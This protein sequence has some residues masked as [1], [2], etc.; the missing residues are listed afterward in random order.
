MAMTAILLT[1]AGLIVAV[2]AALI[3]VTW[4]A[5]QEVRG[6]RDAIAELKVELANQRGTDREWAR[7]MM[8]RKLRQHA[9]ECPGRE[10]TGVRAHP[11]GRWPATG[12]A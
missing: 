8:N 11:S 9:A 5:A 7:D 10:P 12:G 6:L 2:I 1:A 4:R 3:K